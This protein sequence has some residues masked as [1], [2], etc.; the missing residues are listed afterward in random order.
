[1]LRTPV[2][3]S[4]P[5][6]DQES[7][8]KTADQLR[9]ELKRSKKHRIS[10]EP[11]EINIDQDVQVFKDNAARQRYQNHFRNADEERKLRI[12]LESMRNAT[13]RW[14]RLWMEQYI[15]ETYDVMFESS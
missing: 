10:R 1:M 12:D 11:L 6:A 5:A 13:H 3:R 4:A 7:T 9:E 14:H 8:Q 2:K 15:S